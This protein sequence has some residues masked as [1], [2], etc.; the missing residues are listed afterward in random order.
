MAS[1]YQI[2][3]SVSNSIDE[4]LS[5]VDYWV[6]MGGWLACEKAKERPNQRQMLRSELYRSYY[7]VAY[8][9]L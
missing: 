1:A 9:D 2:K 5:Y 6:L 3:D 8:Y 4:E 7:L